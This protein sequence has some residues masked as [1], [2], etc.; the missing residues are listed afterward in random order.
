[1][2]ENLFF[3]GV[4]GVIGNL[5][6]AFAFK[7]AVVH[8]HQQSVVEI[9]DGLIQRRIFLPDQCK[10]IKD[11]FPALETKE[12]VGRFYDLVRFYL[13]FVGTVLITDS[14]GVVF[15]DLLN[16]GAHL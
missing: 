16:Q 6:G 15:A 2:R 3:C 7:A 8:I 13:I 1:M 10:L 14:C 5:D 12:K 9:T 11:L 4:F